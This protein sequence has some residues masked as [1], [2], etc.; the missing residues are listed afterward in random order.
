MPKDLTRE[1][2]YK[3][4]W[5]KPVMTIAKEYGFSDRGLGKLCTRYEIPIPPR[6]YWM[7]IKSGQKIE[8]PPLKK[9]NGHN[10]NC[11]VLDE[12][13][14]DIT[15]K[16]SA[17]LKK[18]I[19][20]EKNNQNKLILDYTTQKYHPIVKVWND[21][22]KQSKYIKTNYKARKAISL[23]LFELEKRG[24]EIGHYDNNPE[25]RVSRVGISG[26]TIGI[27]IRQYSRSYKRKIQPSDGY[28]WK[29]RN[30]DNDLIY[31]TEP[32]DFLKFFVYGKYECCPQEYKETADISIEQAISKVIIYAHKKIERLKNERIEEERKSRINRLRWIQESKYDKYNKALEK[33][34]ELFIEQ[35]KQRREKLLIDSKKW[36]DLK[37]M[38]E[39]IDSIKEQNDPSNEDWLNWAYSFIKD[40]DPTQNNYF[41]SYD[42][43]TPYFT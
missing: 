15:I 36:N 6:G 5:K 33:K 17:S 19:Q 8:I 12:K 24:Y 9:L 3:L 1:E 11:I 32:T 40:I 2:L 10:E 35:E 31:V 20:E 41:R 13:T 26:D 14:P 16:T 42:K 4:I 39:F 22:D 21:L 29:W 18:A 7:R 30:S 28:R 23:L 37:I 43:I 38:R 27:G 25:K 34:R